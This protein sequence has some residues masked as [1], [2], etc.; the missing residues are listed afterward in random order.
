MCK[1]K[2]FDSYERK[3][4]QMNDFTGTDIADLTSSK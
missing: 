1:E 2:F 3:N 4:I